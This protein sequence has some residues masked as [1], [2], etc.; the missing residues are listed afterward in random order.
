MLRKHPALLF[1]KDP[2]IRT[3]SVSPE[4]NCKSVFPPFHGIQFKEKK[5]QDG[6]K[7]PDAASVLL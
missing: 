4:L 1:S 6:L 2:S 7:I 3:T 5:S